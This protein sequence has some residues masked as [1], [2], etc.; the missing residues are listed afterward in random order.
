MALRDLVKDVH[1][2]AE[3]SPFAKLLMSGAISKH[4]YANYL[5]QHHHVD[6]II[7]DDGLQHYRLPHL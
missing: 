7:C 4:Q 1:T 5:Y 3:E 2:E 6:V